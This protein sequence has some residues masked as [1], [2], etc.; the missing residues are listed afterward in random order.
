MRCYVDLTF[1]TKMSAGVPRV[2][3]PTAFSAN[4]CGLSFSP[5]GVEELEETFISDF[6]GSLVAGCVY[7][8]G[9]TQKTT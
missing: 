3:E 2:P 7:V 4:T 1:F 6:D 8:L 9:A 5:M